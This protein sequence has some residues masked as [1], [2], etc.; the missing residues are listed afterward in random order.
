MSAMGRKQPS[1]LASYQIPRASTI[2]SL[3]QIL[4]QSATH[5]GTSAKALHGTLLLVLLVLRLDR[6]AR[7]FP[8]GVG[9]GEEL[10]ERAAVD[11][12]GRAVDGDGLSGEE[13]A[14]VRHEEGGEV[15]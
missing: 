14:A 10:V 13:L 7:L 2:T 15:L 3:P 1:A 4:F 9:P 6:G 11:E 8:V 12:A 5:P